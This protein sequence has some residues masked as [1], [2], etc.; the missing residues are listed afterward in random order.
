MTE[1]ERLA[2]IEEIRQLKAKYW[3]G[4]DSSDGALVRSILAEDCELDYIGCCTDPV[5]GQDHMPAMNVVLRG[6]DSWIADAFKSAGIVTVHQG[7]QNE[8]TV[9]HL[10]TATGIWAFADR[11]FLPPGGAFTRLTGYGHY[12]DPYTLTAE[13][14][15]LR[16]TRITRLW[17]EVSQE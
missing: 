13:G 9:P 10:T 3:R 2:A 4:V 11:F 15:K 1:G 5:S 8:I 7:Y 14:W 16:T 12:H 6:R 17:V